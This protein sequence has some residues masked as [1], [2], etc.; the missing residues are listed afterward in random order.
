[1][2]PGSGT[3]TKAVYVAIIF[4][5]GFFCAVSLP[6]VGFSQSQGV[7]DEGLP[8]YEINASLDIQNRRVSAIQKVY[9]RNNT[10]VAVPSLYFHI[11]PHRSYT[12]DD[13]RMMNRYAGYFKVDPYP[14]GFQSGD[15]S[16]T[17]VFA[18]EAKL[19]YSVEG[20]DRTILKIDLYEPLLPGRS[21]EIEMRFLLDIP[22]S[23]GRFGWHKDIITLT[24]W[25]P[26]LSVL[27]GKGWHTNPYYIFHQPFFSEAAYY[28]L[29]LTV[30]AGQ[31]AVAGCPAVSSIANGDGTETVVF[32]NDQ[33]MRD[34]GLGISANFRK[35]TV[36]QGGYSINSFYAA[37]AEKPGAV[38]AA[39]YAA[40]LMRYHEE[41]FGKYPYK[42]FSIVP[43]YLGFGGDQSSGLIFIDTR[44]YRLPGFLSRYFDFLVSHETGHQWFYNI[45]GSDEYREMFID[46]AM[47]SYWTLRYLEDKYGYDAKVLD[48]PRW[49]SRVVPNFSFR[50]ATI[51]RYMLLAGNGYDRP[52][53]GPLSGFKEPSSIFALAYG[54]GS[55]VLMM[56]ESLIGR[57]AFDRAVARYARE[58][59]FRNFSVE[60]LIRITA[61]ESGKDTRTFLEQWL[62]TDKYCDF[63]IKSVSNNI[64]TV[65]NL[66]DLSMPVETLIKYS[67]G[68][69]A[70]DFWETGKGSRVIGSPGSAKAVSAV[71]DPDNAALLDRD[72]T[73]NRWPRKVAL[74]LVP[75]YFFAYEMPFF[76]DASAYN[77]VA[78]PSAG[79]SSLGLASSASK[80]YDYTLRL[81]SVYD[82]NGKAFDSKFGYDIAHINGSHNSAGFE[83]FDYDSRKEKHDVSGGKLYYRRELWP[84]NYGLFAINDHVSLYLI[85]D[86]KFDSSGNFGGREDIR[87]MIYR[88]KNEAI[89]GIAGSFGRFGPYGDPSYGWRFIPTQEIA[90]HFFGGGEAFWRS[91]VEVQNYYLVSGRLQHKLATRIKAGWGE[92]SHKDLFDIGGSGSLRGYGSKEIQGSHCFFAGVEYRFPVLKDLKIYLP[93]D[94]ANLNSIQGVFFIDAGK[95]WHSSYKES[96]F[97]KN[98]GLGLRFHFNI[99][100]GLERTSVRVDAAKPVNDPKQDIHYWFGIN[101]AF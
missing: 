8:R 78:G 60:S 69:V 3:M 2:S 97:K 98:A 93:F 6:A 62:V 88:K 83:L 96:D 94:I 84:A 23:Y 100:G 35:V 61:E 40:G 27:D 57:D 37:A 87:N 99:C 66:G 85:R 41:R 54:K 19:A 28:K 68:S 75:L 44:M 11:Y 76:Q 56:L 80:P 30:P 13:I 79:G 14:E 89:A 95:A 18:G 55:A 38:K 45:V 4:F 86:R 42:E 67:D 31:K 64:V 91:S 63:R 12:T 16:V 32:E 72:R 52:V 24:R 49:I 53:I 74:K 7:R 15:L 21:V 34:L 26:I 50:S 70:K 33:P 9:F 101:Q 71:I 10:A 17:E 51:S 77:A 65:E 47:N 73:N 46:E 5:A 36:V 81:S 20:G 1:M 92:H 39:E 82:F 43:G 48:L 59:R 58:Y 22:H 29:V 25:Y 90:G